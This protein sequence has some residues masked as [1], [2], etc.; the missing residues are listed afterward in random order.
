LAPEFALRGSAAVLA[1][2][3][4]FGFNPQTLAATDTWVGLDTGGSPTTDWANADNWAADAQPASGDSLVFTSSNGQGTTT[5]TDSLTTSSFLINGI[6]FNAG[7]VAYTLTGNAFELGAAI[8]NNSSNTQTINNAITLSTNHTLTT[9]SSGGNLTFGGNISGASAG[10]TISGG[11][12]VTFNAQNSYTGGTT[13]ADGS[14]LALNFAAVGAPATNIISTSSALSLNGGTLTLNS[15]GSQTFASTTLNAGLSVINVSGNSTVNAGTT[16]TYQPGGTLELIGPE[17]DNAVTTTG[18][19][20]ATG[21]VATTGTFTTPANVSGNANLALQSSRTGITDASTA[22]DTALFGEVGLYDFAIISPTS[23]YTIIGASQ[24]TGGLAGSNGSGGT[25]NDGAYNLLNGTNFNSNYANGGLFDVLG[26]DTAH[27]TDNLEGVRF[28]ANASATVVGSADFSVGGYL[29]TPNVGAFNDFIT[30]DIQ[31]GQRGADLGSTVFFQNNVLGFLNVQAV[32][33]NNSNANDPQGGTYVQSGAGTVNYT[34]VNTYTGQTYLN[35]GV[36]EI[37]ADSAFGAPATA[38]AV[39]LNGGTIFGSVSVNLDNAGSNARPIT[40]LSN[41]GGVAE[42]TGGTLKVDGLVTGAGP[43]IIGIPASAANGNTLG[44]VPGT[45]TINGTATANTAQFA[46]GTVEVTDASNTYTGG[47]VIDSGILQI[48]T[49]TLGT[50]TGIFGGTTTGGPVTLS[51]GTFQWG[52]GFSTDISAQGLVVGSVGGTLD[53]AGNAVTLTHGI[54][55][56]GALTVINSTGTGSITLSGN[57]TGFNGSVALNSGALI[58]SGANYY[59]GATQVNAGTMTLASGG[60]LGNTAITV[61]N[62]ATLLANTGNSGITGTVILGNGSILSQEDGTIGSLSLGGLTINGSSADLDFDMSNTAGNTTDSITVTGGALGGSGIGNVIFNELAGGTAPTSG[63]MYV[64]LTDAGGFGSVTFSEAT[65]SVTIG[66]TTYVPTLST[67]STQL[68]LTLFQAQVNYFWTGATNGSWNT[69]GNFIVSHSGGGNQPVVPQSYSN[70]FLTADTATN[71]S[72]TLDHSFTVN[73]LTFTGTSAVSSNNQTG[74]ENNAVT[75]ANGTGTNILTL[76]GL[77]SFTDADGVNYGPGIGLEVQPG[78][79]GGTIS[80]NINLGASQT[81]ELDS[82]NGLLISGTIANAPSTT[83]T[84]VKTGIGTLTLSASNTYSGGT[85]IT[86]GTVALSSGGSLGSSGLL[87]VNGGT[88]DLAGNNQSVGGLY[89]GGVSTGTV[90]SS[91]GSAVL[92]I[93]DNTSQSY[94]GTITDN[95]AGNGASLGLVFSGTA[96]ETLSGSNSYTGGTTVSSGALVAANNH[97]LGSSTS[98]TGGLLLNPAG[99]ATVDFTSSSPSIGSLAS[100]G[101]GT[102]KVVLGNAGASSPTTLTVGGAGITTV[103]NGVISDEPTGNTS[104]VGS[105]T[106]IGGSLTLGGA[107][108]LNGTTFVNGGALVIANPL[109]LQNSTLEYNGSGSISFGTQTSVTLGGIE[110]SGNISMLNASLAPVAFTIGNNPNVNDTYSGSLTDS[111]SGSSLT[112]A[113]AT[114]TLAGVN[115]YT[116]TTTINGGTLIITGTVGSSGTPSGAALLNGA[117]SSTLTV[118]GGSLYAASL[119]EENTGTINLSAGLISLTGVFGLSIGNAGFG[120]GNLTGGTLN[121]NSLVID[122]DNTNFGATLPASGETTEGLYVDGATVNIATTLADGNTGA[123]DASS[124]NLRMD[125]GSI[126]VGGITT[127][128]NDAASRWSVL[129]INGGVFTDNDPTGTGILVGGGADTTLDAVLYVRNGTLNTT[130]ITVGNSTDAGGNLD[131]ID[132]GGTTNIGFGGIVDGAPSPTVVTIDI[133]LNTQT[134]APTITALAS[135]SSSAPLT[136]ANSSGGVAPTFQTSTGDNITLSG[137]L[138]GA[139]G[140]TAAGTGILTLSGTGT[141]TGTTAVN[142]GTLVVSGSVTGTAVTTVSHGADLEVDGLLTSTSPAAV[143]GELSGVGSINGATLNTGT[144][145]PGDTI[146][147]SAVGTLTSS[148]NVSLGSSSVFSIRIGLTAPGTDADQLSVTGGSFNLSDG[149]TTLQLLDTANVRNAPIGSLY[150]IVNGGASATGVSSD[151]FTNAPGQGDPVTTALNDTFDVYYGVDP[152]N[153]I[154]G[155]DIVLELVS[156]P[157][158]GTWASLLG[159]IGMLVAWQRSRRRRS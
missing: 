32:M 33:Q 124:N 50:T 144:L 29:V 79:A 7:A 134:T 21:D 117:I 73:S 10:V 70:I 37:G 149:T 132:Y 115:S 25:A 1:L 58:I 36:S 110:G 71:Y 44:L 82:A 150:V 116:G 107:D 76:T 68:I 27:N 157:E 57:N 143:S 60:S 137:V 31:T 155:N 158:P 104:A 56:T 138:S 45:G 4:L 90:T 19:Q 75:L 151:W 148:N 85:T 145:A 20:A 54:S 123:G 97:A 127:V 122:R 91:A 61:A 114:N 120:F 112:V 156:V 74:A 139:G 108:T 98:A 109:A 43:L 6:T 80:A 35:G 78:S 22:G 13:L 101:A 14:T 126:T 34:G 23:P 46:A 18:G 87:T 113:G 17:Y 140:L 130:G 67:N 41:G 11:G 95:N 92:N 63:Q 59:T 9:D 30:T 133:G 5:L 64:L 135:W 125:A 88:F 106:L 81:W 99:S 52:T 15:G 26:T 65:P 111:G 118:S 84:L 55:G 128:A 39:N 3:A 62:G 96:T 154:A 100:S 152:T 51:G 129:D 83:D 159:G 102:S 103:F 131:F 86:A 141:Y 69:V 136:L 28:N 93:T 48:D 66:G 8:T 38:A 121:A 119:Q 72:Q 42:V 105:L 40:L 89:D 53:S 16:F 94:S 77:S 147:S 24:G 142:G 153:T 2:F 146:G 47:T 12:T 49:S